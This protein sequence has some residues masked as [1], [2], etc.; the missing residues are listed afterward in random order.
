MLTT[1]LQVIFEDAV[2][3]QHWVNH[4]YKYFRMPLFNTQEGPHNTY[5][6][7]TN[8]QIATQKQKQEQGWAQPH[9]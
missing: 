8:M 4:S 1:C 7:S 6:R 5:N 3:A 2:G 9:S